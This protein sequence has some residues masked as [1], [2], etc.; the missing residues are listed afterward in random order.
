MVPWDFENSPGS[1]LA[2]LVPQ[3]RLLKGYRALDCA[4]RVM[5]FLPDNSFVSLS[6]TDP[7]YTQSILPH[8]QNSEWIPETLRIQIET[9]MEVGE[10]GAIDLLQARS[11]TPVSTRSKVGAV[12]LRGLAGWLRELHLF[13]IA[14]YIVPG[15][16]RRL[17]QPHTLIR[18]PPC[19]GN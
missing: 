3:H 8:P 4:P 12:P 13:I 9:R 6:T 1:R 5:Y 2:G 15:I 17:H 18:P 19:S 10:R 16:C 11:A 7:Q 14:I